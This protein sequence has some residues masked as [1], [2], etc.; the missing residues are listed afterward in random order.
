[1][2]S[3]RNIRIG[4]ALMSAA[5][6]LLVLY[7]VW[8]FSRSRQNTVADNNN[9]TTNNATNISMRSGRLSAVAN[10]DLPA[11][12]IITADSY[13]MEPMEEGVSTAGYVIDPKEQAV[14]FITRAPIRKNDRIRTTNLVGHIS[15][16]GVAGALQPGTRAMMVPIPSK[17]TLHD[18][19]RVGDTVDIIAAFDQQESRTIVE[20]VR[21]L[22]VDVFVKDHPQTSGAQRGPYKVPPASVRRD[23]PPAPPQTSTPSTAAAPQA[24]QPTPAPTPTP[25]P[26]PAPTAAPAPA[27]TLEVTPDQ[28]NRLFLAQ[29]SGAAIDFIIVPRTGLP[30][31]APGP[32]DVAV[33]TAAVT[34]PQIAPYAA[35]QKK[36]GA[37]AKT[38]NAP[39]AT[40]PTARSNSRINYPS[41]DYDTTGPD[42]GKVPIID[43]QE[44]IGPMTPPAPRTYEIPIYAD[45]KQVR[46][47]TVLKP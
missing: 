23:D 29:N 24:G 16:V 31:L 17:P 47:D 32:T 15:Q 8:Q 11:R 20:G 18:L 1:M 26:T 39:R 9:N 22:A 13:K 40:T 41:D 36:T 46:T 5:F 33:R 2:R 28:A 42:F 37:A 35:Q 27:L 4:I 12:S 10:M 3:N 25:T 45:G 6:L 38:A 14:G 34:R 43:D 19:V 21:V 7:L 30:P 44:I